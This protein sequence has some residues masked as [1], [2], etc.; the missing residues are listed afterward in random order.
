MAIQEHDIKT[1]A[2]DNELSEPRPATA[3][4]KD[5]I[6]YTEF[7]SELGGYFVINGKSYPDTQPINVKHGQTVRIRLIGASEMMHPMHL[8]GHYFNIVAEDGRTMAQ[9][10]QKDTVQVAPG[11]TYDLTFNAWAAP[12][13]VY[14]F[15]C[16]ILTH[17]SDPGQSPDQMGGL[18]TLVE[19]AK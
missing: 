4:S 10:I 3:S 16:H 6:E 15:H 18:I 12:G 9:P 14:P 19:Y 1:F 7:I 17:P 8:H 2:N 13:S 5:D 11:E